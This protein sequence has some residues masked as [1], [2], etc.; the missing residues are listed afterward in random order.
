[1]ETVPHVI[2]QCLLDWLCKLTI[3]EY[4]NRQNIRSINFSFN[5]LKFGIDTYYSMQP[6]QYGSSTTVV[7]TGV[8]QYFNPWFRLL[9]TK[10][11]VRPNE[12]RLTSLV[13]CNQTLSKPSYWLSYTRVQWRSQG[14]GWGWLPPKASSCLLYTSDAADE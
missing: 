8:V 3:S 10:S 1:M 11:R 7:A 9:S 2:V 6:Y 12:G 14:G 13:R 5:Q 4:I